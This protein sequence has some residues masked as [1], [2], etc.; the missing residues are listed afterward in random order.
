MLDL[1][2]QLCI[3]M[4]GQQRKITTLAELNRHIPVKSKVYSALC[5]NICTSDRIVLINAKI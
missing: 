1:P 4:R 3:S 5:I 2:T